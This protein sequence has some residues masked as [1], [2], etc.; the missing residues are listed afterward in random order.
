M[1][2]GSQPVRTETRSGSGRTRLEPGP[3][4]DAR[5]VWHWVKV[6]VASENRAGAFP[7][8]FPE[9]TVSGTLRRAHCCPGLVEAMKP[10]QVTAERH[11]ASGRATPDS[12][13]TLVYRGFEC[14]LDGFR[15]PMDRSRDG[16][17]RVYP[18]GCFGGRARPPS[19]GFCF[20]ERFAARRGGAMANVSALL[21]PEHR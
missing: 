16:I 7:G 21:R 12:R 4:G 5:T 18:P 20:I 1:R 2:Q 10:R 15:G 14:L 17:D 9:L 3:Q 13:G 19:G 11:P 8:A 6:R